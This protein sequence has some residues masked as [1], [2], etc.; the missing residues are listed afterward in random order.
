[1]CLMASMGFTS[2]KAQHQAFDHNEQ[3]TSNI[4]TIANVATTPNN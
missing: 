2:L 1:M 4:K 3:V